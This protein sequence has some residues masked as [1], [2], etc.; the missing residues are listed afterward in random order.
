[1]NK[2]ERKCTNSWIQNEILQMKKNIMEEIPE[3]TAKKSML[4]NCNTAIEYLN[5]IEETEIEKADMLATFINVDL[6]KENEEL[7]KSITEK[8]SSIEELEKD[9]ECLR[10][11]NDIICLESKMYQDQV[12][13]LTALKEIYENMLKDKQ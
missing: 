8:N 3:S 2:T 9:N 6:E 10:K 12:N 4:A 7:K 1:M 11:L 5:N 13:S